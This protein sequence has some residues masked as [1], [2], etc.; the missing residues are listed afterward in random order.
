MVATKV[1]AEVENL[2]RGSMTEVRTETSSRTIEQ[3]PQP[4]WGVCW[5][6]LVW[7][8]GKVK[9]SFPKW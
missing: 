1:K 6:M 5:A 9:E 4:R 2:T 8:E 3:E 7:T